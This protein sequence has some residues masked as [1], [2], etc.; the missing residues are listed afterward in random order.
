MLS[1]SRTL[2]MVLLCD[3]AAAGLG[4]QTPSADKATVVPFGQEPHAKSLLYTAHLRMYDVTVQPGASTLDHSHD[5]DV[6]TVALGDASLRTREAGGEW[7]APRPYAS[8]AVEV[9]T[10]TGTPRTDRHEN[11][12]ATPYHVYAVENLRDAGWTMPRLIEAPGTRLAEQ[13]RS[14]AV[15]D[16]RLNSTTMSTNHV[17]QM[18]TVVILISGGVEVQGGGGESEFRMLQTGRWFPSQWDQPHTLT[19][20]G[21]SEAHVIE[22]EV[23]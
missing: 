18:P 20:V 23:R 1:L 14:F 3:A 11:L 17:H 2:A 13:S 12:G 7:A 19:L 4:A 5:H 15:Y 10:H 21:S 8:G 16:V 22:V 9:A 6:V